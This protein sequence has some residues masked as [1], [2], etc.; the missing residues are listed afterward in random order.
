[1]FDSS[2]GPR[3]QTNPASKGAGDV[4][5]LTVL[6]TDYQRVAEFDRCTWTFGPEPRRRFACA[7]NSSEL[8]EL[9]TKRYA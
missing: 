2:E 7:S 8:C 3:S 6:A 4:T 9:N 5:S 1:M